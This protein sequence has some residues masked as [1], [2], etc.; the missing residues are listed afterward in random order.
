MSGPQ[1]GLIERLAAWVVDN[2]IKAM[3][4]PALLAIIMALGMALLIFRSD[5]LIFFSDSNEDLIAFEAFEATYTKSNSLI[6]LVTAKGGDV[7]TPEHLK[8]LLDL[9]DKAWELPSVRRVDSVVNFQN[10]AADGDDIVIDHLLRAGDPTGAAAIERIRQEALSEAAL[11]NRLISPD[12]DVTGVAVNFNISADQKDRLIPEINKAARAI[13]AEIAQENPEL[14]FRLSGS[15]ALDYAFV[16]AILR[17]AA[18]LVPVMVVVILVVITLI[19]GSIW[20]TL[21]GAAVVGLSIAAAMGLGGFLRIPLSPPS[22]SAP[23]VIV[24]IATADCIHMTWAILRKLNENL[25]KKQAIFRAILITWRPITF[26]SLTTAIGFFSLN[27]AESPPF[28][29]LGTLAG[30]G[31]LIAMVLSLTLM[32]AALYFL[33]IK[34]RDGSRVLGRMCFGLGTFVIRHRLVVL[35]CGGAV[36]LGIGAMAFT[37]DLN[38]RYVNYFDESFQFRRDTDYMDQHLTGFDTIE[39]SLVQGEDTGIADPDYLREVQAFSDWFEEQPEVIHVNSIVDV[40]KTMNRVLHGDEPDQYQIPEA[41]NNAAQYLM[42]YEM[43]LPTGIDLKNQITVDKSASRM[44]VTMR[45]IKTEQMLDLVERAEI[46]AEDNL[47]IVA[48]PEATGASVLFSHIGMRNITS[49]LLGTAIALVGVSA[50]MFVLFRSASAG[51]AAT[52]TNL[53]PALVA[54]GFWGI[55]VGEVGLAVSVI[56]AMTLGIVVDDTIHFIDKYLHARREL[57]MGPDQAVL[58]AFGAAGPAMITTTLALCAGFLCLWFSGFQINSW[59][60]LM[61]AITIFVALVIDLLLLPAILV[62]IGRKVG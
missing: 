22:A 19:L 24:T 15:A 6:F 27:F 61:A 62:T 2:P 48:V 32:P 33:P 50:L 39:Y 54:I 41:R 60:G 8:A 49:M 13:I 42:L 38:D 30:F 52:C 47:E 29:H 1:S 31:A 7:F 58:D 16:E 59:I 56:A 44:T 21:I 5:H 9:T 25:P 14:E 36:A 3:L 26:T 12:G 4:L 51:I 23:S 28:Q 45:E 17:D 57:D 34:P 10:A 46:W 35:I 11:V 40:M 53:L 18:M 20:A 55:F 37:N 43:S